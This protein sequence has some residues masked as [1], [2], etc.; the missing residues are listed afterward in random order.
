M[1]ECLPDVWKNR[2]VLIQNELLPPAWESRGVETPTVMPVWFEKKPGF[3]VKVTRPSPVYGPAS[4]PVVSAMEALDVPT[5]RIEDQDEMLFELALKNV[6]ILTL[7]IAGLVAGQTAGE[8]WKDH[9]GLAEEVAKEAI[10]IQEA[11]AGR[12]LDRERL[13]RE[14]SAAVGDRPEQKTTGRSAPERLYRALSH[15]DAH[16]LAVGKL[17]QIQNRISL[18]E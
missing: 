16:G 6:Y 8:L 2:L 3:W 11:L 10:D 12:E 13:L 5:R 9:R 15:A 7:N 14:L 1:L 4:D 17:R 18:P